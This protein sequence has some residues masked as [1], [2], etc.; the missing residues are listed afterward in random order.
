MITLPIGLDRTISDTF[1]DDLFDAP[2][3]P[4][5]VRRRSF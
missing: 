1:G 2:N 4:L 5:S 3:R